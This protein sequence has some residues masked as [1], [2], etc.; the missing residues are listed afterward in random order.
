MRRRP[1]APALGRRRAAACP[2]W[3]AV[4][5]RAW[6]APWPASAAPWPRI[7]SRARN[8]ARRRRAWRQAGPS[9]PITRP[10]TVV[11]SDQR[12]FPFQIQNHSGRHRHSCAFVLSILQTHQSQS[13]TSYFKNALYELAKGTIESPWL[14]AW[15]CPARACPPRVWARPLASARACPPPAWDPP[16]ASAPACPPR[17]C[18]PRASAPDPLDLPACKRRICGIG[19][20]P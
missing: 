10:L 4:P 20:I 9:L 13:S 6:P 1:R 14:Q 7:C 18:R 15:V 12:P 19:R 2:A 11:F 3:R 8:S 5:P 16:P 17:V